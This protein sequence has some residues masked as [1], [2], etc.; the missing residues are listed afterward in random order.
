MSKTQDINM[1]VWK[2]VINCE[3]VLV[4]MLMDND[5][6]HYRI[7]LPNNLNEFGSLFFKHTWTY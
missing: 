2:C 4:W 7:S 6:M 5:E 1:A 3:F